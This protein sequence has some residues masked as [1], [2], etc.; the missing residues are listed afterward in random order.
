LPKINT[1]TSGKPLPLL[2]QLFI[3]E[4]LKLK[5]DEGGTVH[6]CKLGKRSFLTLFTDALV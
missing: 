5:H 6:G 4:V 1:L 3:F 2:A